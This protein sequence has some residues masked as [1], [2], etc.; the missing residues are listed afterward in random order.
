MRLE[1]YL[2]L[3]GYGSRREM[4]RVIKE[5]G[6]Q[7]N[8]NPLTAPGYRVHAK[9]K[10]L[11]QGEE[12]SETVPS[13]RLWLYHKPRSVMTTHHDPEGRPT[14]FEALREGGLP[15][16]VSVGRLD[17]QSEGLLLLTNNGALARYLEHPKQAFKRTY[18]VK[19]WGTLKPQRLEALSKGITLEGV[20][21]RGMRVEVLKETG[22]QAWLEIELQ[23]GKNREIRRVMSH[24]NLEVS[25]LIRIAYGPYRLGDLAVGAWVEED[26]TLLGEDWGEES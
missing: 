22:R 11:F 16:V 3:R 10:I 25:R 21:Y 9:D 7:V 15:H 26:V 14:A 20:R 8:G 13:V 24:F 5:G 4:A 12:V 1:K 6:V 23:E 17:Y 19:V 18:R 2:A